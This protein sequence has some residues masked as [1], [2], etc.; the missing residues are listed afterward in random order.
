MS[1]QRIHELQSMK[2]HEI[3]PAHVQEW[4][5]LTGHTH[6]SS[7]SHALG[8]WQ[9]FGEIVGDNDMEAASQKLA[10]KHELDTKSRPND[11][12]LYRG[13]KSDPRE[14]HLL[15]Y[16]SKNRPTGLS[17]TENKHKADAFGRSNMGSLANEPQ[18][19]V[20]AR[21][22]TVKGIRLKDYEIEEP[23]QSDRKASEFR[24][25][26]EWLVHPQSLMGLETQTR[27]IKRAKKSK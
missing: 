17:F 20:V 19:V 3:T 1:R 14:E 2:A 11:R 16:R 25:E 27:Q 9:H 4:R 21:K 18:R 12:V 8:N 7:L 10:M 6:E 26:R 24:G 13:T 23:E 15:N 5:E 22:G